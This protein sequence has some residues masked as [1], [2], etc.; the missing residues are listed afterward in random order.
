MTNNYSVFSDNKKYQTYD[1]IKLFFKKG[2]AKVSPRESAS[3]PTL[4][5]GSRLLGLPLSTGGL[6]RT[7]SGAALR[8]RNHV[9]SV[10]NGDRVT[11][12]ADFISSSFEARK[13]D[14]F[15]RF[16]LHACDEDMAAKKN[17]ERRRRH[18]TYVATPVS[19]FH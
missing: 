18:F 9:A 1:A 16:I 14:F 3:R 17:L 11:D 19:V 10:L 2:A 7:V 5:G 8:E 13:A 15:F 4:L 12:S 6:G